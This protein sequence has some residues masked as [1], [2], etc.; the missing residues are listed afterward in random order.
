MQGELSAL[1]ALFLAHNKIG[2]LLSLLSDDVQTA[3]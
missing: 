2:F 1:S 3:V